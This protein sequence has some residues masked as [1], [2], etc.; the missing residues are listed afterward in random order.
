MNEPKGGDSFHQQEWSD[1]T[2]IFL[3][4]ESMRGSL[5][6]AIVATKKLTSGNHGYGK[7]QL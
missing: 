3:V 6:A 1:W 7:S 5:A 4:F 2:H